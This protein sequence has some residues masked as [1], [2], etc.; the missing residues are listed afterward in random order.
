MET[1]SLVKHLKLNGTYTLFPKIRS[2][3]GRSLILEGG[4][5]VIN[6]ASCDY[7]GLSDNEEIKSAAIEAIKKY[8]TNI[9]GPMIFSGYTE[10]HEMLEQSYETLFNSRKSL[11]FTTSFQVNTGVIPIISQRYD[12][13]VMD[14]LSHVSLYN[15]VQASGKKFIIFPHKNIEI[16]NKIIITNKG[17]EI[18]LITDGVF[19]ADGDFADLSL[20]S[21]L[22]KNNPNVSLYVDDAHGVGMLGDRGQGLAEETN[23]LNNI[24][25]LVGTMSKAFGSTGGFISF[26]NDDIY[27]IIRHVCPT[28]NASRAVSPGVAAASCMSLELNKREGASRRKS[29]LR[30]SKYAH[31]KFKFHNINILKS[32]SAVIP[33]V[34]KDPV[35][36]A[37]VNSLLFEKG[38]LGSLFVP[39]YVE[40]LKSRIRLNL[41]YNH[42]QSDVDMLIEKVLISINESKI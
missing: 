10:Y 1:K 37:K 9:S 30:L 34:F 27:D 26:L 16:L 36:A 24:D 15:G 5:E 21:D 12:L 20:L 42:L 4:N 14:K 32:E 23:S 35:Q 41:T 38:I 39:P 8:G 25:F 13:I 19:S 33:L 31:S 17:K 11:M 3:C 2:A 18:L 40:R 22:K 6:F 28:Y 7:L 29:L